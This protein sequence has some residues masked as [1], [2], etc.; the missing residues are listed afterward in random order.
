MAALI[1]RKSAA[2]TAFKQ[3][4]RLLK[5]N[6]SAAMPQ[7]L[8]GSAHVITST[9]DEPAAAVFYKRDFLSKRV[10][11]PEMMNRQKSEVFTSA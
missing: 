4:S 5:L 7:I 10:L 1:S 2:G 6:V 8:C 11:S 3:S 9:V